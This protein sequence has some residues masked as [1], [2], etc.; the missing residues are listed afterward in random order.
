MPAVQNALVITATEEGLWAHALADVK[1]LPMPFVLPRE[2]SRRASSW[3]NF[4]RST[5][6]TQYEVPREIYESA[7]EVRD[8]DWQEKRRAILASGG[9]DL[10]MFS[11]KKRERGA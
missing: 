6:V 3:D 1:A 10:G 8:C 7:E 5:R 9:Q 2:L 11:G 4:Q